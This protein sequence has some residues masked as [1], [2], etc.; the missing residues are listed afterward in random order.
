MLG[1]S[2][3]TGTCNELSTVL[4]EM[5]A[6]SLYTP[7]ARWEPPAPQ[8]CRRPHPGLRANRAGDRE[9]PRC[10]RRQ[11]G[12]SPGTPRPR[13]MEPAR[14]GQRGRAARDPREQPR[15]RCR[16]GTGRD[17][18]AL[19][20]RSRRRAPRSP[21]AGARRN[22]RQGT[23]R[24]PTPRPAE[25]PQPLSAR[26]GPRIPCGAAKSPPAPQRPLN[27]PAIPSGPGR[28]PSSPRDPSKSPSV[29]SAL[30][31]SLHPFRIPLNPPPLPQ[32]LPG[33][34]IPS[35][36]TKSPSSTQ[37]PAVPPC[38][39]GSPEIAL[40]PQGLAGSPIPSSLTNPS[41]SVPSGSH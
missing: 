36:P 11:Q 34:H 40:S 13:H 37:H 8:P 20:A 12:A 25:F 9:R 33:S 14:R 31:G 19:A 1:C 30:A 4:L 17:R 23:R 18:P 7:G 32:R 3:S 27:P 15:G 6:R 10:H 2:P 16:D 24:S 22:G 39:R 5:H 35:D 28:V 26:L 29:P 41:Q 21:L 38:P